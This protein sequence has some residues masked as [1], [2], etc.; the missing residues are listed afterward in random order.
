MNI[1]HLR[2]FTAKICSLGLL[3][4][5]LQNIGAYELAMSQVDDMDKAYMAGDEKTYHER[6]KC[7]LGMLNQIAARKKRGQ[8]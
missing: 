2:N 1:E 3:K 5:D 7:I 4:E 8:K 6:E